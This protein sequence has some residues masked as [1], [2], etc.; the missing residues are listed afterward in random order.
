MAEARDG[1]SHGRQAGS[2]FEAFSPA[3]H[4]ERCAFGMREGSKRIRERVYRYE[5]DSG[6]LNFWTQGALFPISVLAEPSNVR[7]AA[8]GAS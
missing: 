2:A 1:L 6:S 5:L 8:P 4:R 7:S 3:H